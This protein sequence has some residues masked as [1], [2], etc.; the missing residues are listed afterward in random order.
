MGGL[1]GGSKSTST[2]AERVGNIRIQTAA[3]G[4]PI[5]LIYGTTRL[6]ANL[7][8]YDSFVATPHTE[9]Q[10]GGKGG[11][12]SSSNTTYSYSA[13]VLFG[14]CEGEI[15]GIPQVAR[16][17][18]T[19][20]LA[21]QGMTLFTGAR[22][23]TAWSHLATSYPTK[24]LGYFGTAYIAVQNLDLG[25]DATLPNFSF[26]VQG[27]NIAP[28]KSD[29]N[30]ADII[31]DLLTNQYYGAGI[32]SSLM[33][34]LTPLSNYC[35]AY[36]ILLSPAIIEQQA[37]FDTIKRLLSA[38]NSQIVYSEGKIKLIPY[39]DVAL[40]ANGV[41]YTPSVTPI[42]D[43]TDDDYLDLD[44]PIHITRSSPS[45]AFNSVK[46]EYFNR[47]NNYNIETDE[48]SDLANAELYGYRPQDVTVIHDIC[49]PDIAHTVAQLLL[50]RVLYI[51]N[52]YVFVVS[53]KYC[54][55]E[56]MD[57]VTI[58][59]TIMGI[60]QLQIRIIEITEDE[61]FRLTITA[62]DFPFGSATASL[63][64]KQTTESYTANYNISGGNTNTPMVMEAPDT[65]SKS[66]EIWVGA[67]GGNL[68]GGCDVYVSYDGSS[69]KQIGSIGT[70]TKQG[71][72]VTDTTTAITVN[73]AMSNSSMISGS[74]IDF[75]NNSPLYYVGEELL[76]YQNVTL[77]AQYQYS[78]NPLN[79][80]LYGTTSSV[81][82][83]GTLISQVVESA[84][85][86]IPFMDTQ[87]GQQIYIK[88]P[89]KNVY[90]GGMQSITDVAPI[91]YTISGNAYQSPLPDV[92]GIIDY[93]KGT[94]TYLKWD[95]ISDFRTPIDYEVRYGTTWEQ[96]QVL[97]R[98]LTTD[99]I[100]QNN[101]SYW[102]KA[103]YLYQNTNLDIYSTNA[104]GITITGA[105]LAKNVITTWDEKA[106]SWVG[107]KSADV[108][109][110]SG[111]L[112][113][114]G[115]SG[116]YEVS[117]AHIIDIGTAQSCNVTLSYTATGFNPANLVDSWGL[118]DSLNDIDGI[119]GGSWSVTPQIAIAG[120]DGVFGAW[121]DFY[122]T[123]YVGRK[124]KIQLAM[125]SL[126][127]TVYINVSSLVWSVDVPDRIDVGNNVSIASG[128]TAITYSRTFQS[129]P[130]T[131]ITILNATAGDDTIL[132]S[133]TATG[134]MIQVRNGGSGV[135]RSINWLS[136]GY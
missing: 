132:T 26:E 66:L 25:S 69:Y 13:D 34:S 118:I 65:L 36:G 104:V 9:T 134:F 15:V 85:L 119:V 42:Y 115:L 35:T 4:K 37:I 24:S 101:G 44:T 11:G 79:R 43:F 116:T 108:T 110:V 7:I 30:P 67:S 128:G 16:E 18:T 14:L 135:A 63:Y 109:V 130:N 98:V 129:S 80:G 72:I 23:Q 96:G 122:P 103:H 41:T 121:K 75:S 20:T 86:K 5:P 39:G 73:M 10:S 8:W 52:K 29:A 27:K 12:G 48:A 38:C 82:T 55:L 133:Q 62:E 31:N 99:F 102:I 94:T 59:D 91:V 2:T 61:E 58:T 114:S 106:T 111:D 92:T 123:D 127:S 87:I 131:Q 124:F 95:A 50:N 126:S 120:N 60:N 84:V 81:K 6:A 77:T 83:A 90:G 3:Y 32:P 71:V 88:L 93:Y 107:T 117:S 70:P 45:D 17:K 54:L 100:P 112:Q 1:F 74:A 49:D 51:R 57:I 136:Q 21:E 22:P 46:I 78:L 53:W 40:T 28:L 76:S 125:T 113:L 19:T 64:P 33:A 47:A 105:S 97:G 89:S 68:W 56:P